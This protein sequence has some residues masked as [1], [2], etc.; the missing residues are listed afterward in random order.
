MSIQRL[1]LGEKEVRR[2]VES[3]FPDSDT[4]SVSDIE[5]WI[6]EGQKRLKPELAADP[7]QTLCNEDRLEVCEVL[8]DLIRAG[9]L[10]PGTYDDPTMGWPHVYVTTKGGAYFANK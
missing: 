2:L 8:W 6:V 3:A 7:S 4:L 1:N 5:R 10:N 9:Y